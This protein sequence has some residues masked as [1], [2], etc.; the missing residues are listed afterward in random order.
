[1]K[2]SLTRRRLRRPAA[3]A[4]PQHLPREDA[5]EAGRLLPRHELALARPAEHP[6]RGRG[7]RGDEPVV[8]EVL[9]EVR[10]RLAAP[11][12]AQGPGRH[13]PD[14]L[15]AVAE[16]AQ[17]VVVG[18]VVEPERADGLERRRPHLG[19]GVSRPGEEIV[20]GARR[21]GEADQLGH[22]REVVGADPRVHDQRVRDARPELP[23]RLDD[24]GALV[25]RRV[26]HRAQQRRHAAGIAEVPEG[27]DGGRAHLVVRIVEQREQRPEH[28]AG[29]HA[30]EGARRVGLGPPL[31]RVE[32]RDPA[33][34]Q[35]EPLGREPRR[36][37]RRARRDAERRDQEPA[38]LA[39][40]ARR[41]RLQPGDGRVELRRALG[42]EDRVDGGLIPRAQP[43]LARFAQVGDAV[44]HQHVGEEHAERGEAGLEK[45]DQV[46]AEE[47]REQ[48]HRHSRPAPV[49]RRS[50]SRSASW[51]RRSP[52]EG[53]AVCRCWWYQ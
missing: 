33:V 53:C 34:D 35:A 37:D 2:A 17:R 11:G 7:V 15:V 43:R 14:A 9:R 10:G 22:G 5:G 3:R 30:A 27:L 49:W 51:K 38:D 42:A 50:A 39:E 21:A 32:V 40:V 6:Q 8:A 18:A 31:V 46:V 36:G 29:A 13:R 19:I 44:A 1:M 52:A 45:Q 28:A 48:E 23:D 20:G 16:R 47:V 24:A 25:P 26:G 41:R 4:A 12:A